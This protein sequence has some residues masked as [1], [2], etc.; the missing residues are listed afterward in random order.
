MKQLLKTDADVGESATSA[1]KVGHFGELSLLRQSVYVLERL[2]EGM[3]KDQMV[4]LCSGDEQLVSIWIDFLL[5]MSL[6]QRNRSASAL[7][8]DAFQVTETGRLAIE[9]Y[10]NVT[11]DC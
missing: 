11:S 8:A 10:G 1:R 6:L 7:N 4:A 9:K 2:D 3:T 5:S